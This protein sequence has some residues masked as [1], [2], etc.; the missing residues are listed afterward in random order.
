[1]DKHVDGDVQK[2]EVGAKHKLIL[3]TPIDKVWKD[4]LEDEYF[5]SDLPKY[6]ALK[7]DVAK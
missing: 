5:D 7:T 3:I 1:M 2:F 6:Y 4:A